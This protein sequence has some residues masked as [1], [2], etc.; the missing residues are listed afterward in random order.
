MQTSGLIKTCEKSSNEP[1]AHSHLFG[2]QQMVYTMSEWV[3]TQRWDQVHVRER[4]L[5]RRQEASGGRCLSDCKLKTET[6]LRATHK[7]RIKQSCGNPSLPLWSINWGLAE[8]QL[9]IIIANTVPQP[10][11]ILMYNW[12]RIHVCVRFIRHPIKVITAIESH[13]YRC[14]ALQ[15]HFKINTVWDIMSFIPTWR[16][17]FLTTF[18]LIRIW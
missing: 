1:K 15:N 6:N 9:T 2:I 5:T 10:T 14:L 17:R 13:P 7:S 8:E 16:L 3:I 11:F 18:H 4:V 12:E